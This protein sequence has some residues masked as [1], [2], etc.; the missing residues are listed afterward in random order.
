[1][2]RFPRPLL[3]VLLATFFP[4]SLFAA[5]TTTYPSQLE[6]V[7]VVT[8]EWPWLR[9][10][11]VLG[12]TLYLTT[13]HGKLSAL[14]LQTGRIVDDA[15]PVERGVYEE[16]AIIS[17]SM[18]ISGGN[19]FVGS[20]HLPKLLPEWYAYLFPRDSVDCCGMHMMYGLTPPAIDGTAIYVASEDGYLY[21]IGRRS[22]RVLWRKKLGGVS[23]GR[24][25]VHRGVVFTAG[26]DSCLT[27]LNVHDGRL[28]WKR[29]LGEAVDFTSPEFLGNDLIIA[30][31]S[32]TVFRIGSSS[33]ILRWSSRVGQCFQGTVAVGDS[34][35]CAADRS[36][37]FALSLDGRLLWSRPF[38]G[39][40]PTIR[41]GRVYY[42]SRT[43]QVFV[44]RGKTGEVVST[45]SV[46]RPGYFARPVVAREYF[47]VSGYGKLYCFKDP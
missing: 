9:T 5:I 32:G 24:P 38:P 43:G 8:T 23:F 21:R 4:P 6:Q 16:P 31:R 1:M 20:F 11:A 37:L 34:L 18:Y 2:P 12:S 15:S 28:R 39:D 27:A 47:L 30:G 22:G 45:C 44:F 3:V 46:G 26:A 13:V 40:S 10:P 36:G 19:A 33:G 17:G 7:W 35:I 29:S 41:K 42:H 14:D 25:L